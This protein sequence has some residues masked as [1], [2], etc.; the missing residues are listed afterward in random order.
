MSCLRVAYEADVG[1]TEPEI[2]HV[3]QHQPQ[4]RM[5]PEW[6]RCIW[7]GNAAADIDRFGST[8]CAG[9]NKLIVHHVV[10]PDDDLV[11]IEVTKVPIA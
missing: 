9:P 11:K 10:L 8:V 6:M 5:N 2:T 4:H 3:V 7:C 1:M